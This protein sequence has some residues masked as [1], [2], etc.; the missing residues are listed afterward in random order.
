[1]NAAT[2]RTLLSSN[3]LRAGVE[4]RRREGPAG[5]GASRT[6][7]TTRAMR[8]STDTRWWHRIGDRQR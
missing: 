7:N 4:R 1:M 5:A 6:M 8:P 3:P 2:A